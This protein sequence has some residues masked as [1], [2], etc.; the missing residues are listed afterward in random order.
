MN[1]RHLFHAGNRA[2]V[3]KHAVLALALTRLAAKDKPF[4]FIDTHG[5]IGLYDLQA[6]AARKTLEAEGGVKALWRHRHEAPE[7]FAPYLSAIAGI[8]AADDCRYYP[9]SPAVALSQ[10]RAADKAIIN[11][12]HP[13]DAHSLASWARHDKRLKITRQDAWA[14]LV[15]LVPPPEKRGLVLI[16]PPFEKTTEWNDLV[17]AMEKALP[18]WNGGS[19]LIWYPIKMNSSEDQ[20]IAAL[21]AIPKLPESWRMEWCWQ[22]Q[23]EPGLSGNGLVLVNPP[24]PLVDSLQKILTWLHDTLGSQTGRI[25]LNRL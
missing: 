3:M 25:S 7:A 9:G 12:L 4:R 21:G 5:G 22:S 19:Y 10:L 15:S 11:E 18:R 6:D 20:A 24:Y 13:D 14:A 2:D 23:N 16:D 17:T 8:N 1:Y